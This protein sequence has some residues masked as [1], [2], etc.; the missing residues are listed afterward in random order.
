MTSPHSA[1]VYGKIVRSVT[2]PGRGRS[3]DFVGIA[4]RNVGADGREPEDIL[5]SV[6]G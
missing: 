2:G 3:V 6:N 4:W 1:S 5:V